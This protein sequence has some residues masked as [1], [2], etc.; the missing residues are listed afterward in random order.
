[1]QAALGLERPDPNHSWNNVREPARLKIDQV[2]KQAEEQRSLKNQLAQARQR[3]QKAKD[4]ADQAQKHLDQWAAHWRK[5]IAGLGL[6]QEALPKAKQDR[7]EQLDEILSL[8]RAAEALD[9]RTADIQRNRKAILRRL[10]ELRARLT[11]AACPEAIVESLQTDVDALETRLNKARETETSR[12]QPRGLRHHGRRPTSS[13]IP[14]ARITAA[15]QPW[16]RA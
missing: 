4:A 12:K 16:W 15:Q 9:Q 5:A 13:P 7:L 3:L 10:C 1:M 6:D 2:Q 8:L 11:P 14:P